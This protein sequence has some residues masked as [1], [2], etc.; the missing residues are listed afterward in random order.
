MVSLDY[1]SIFGKIYLKNVK[2]VT[3]TQLQKKPT[4]SG[5]QQVITE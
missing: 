1:V 3:I 5:R 2:G 4:I